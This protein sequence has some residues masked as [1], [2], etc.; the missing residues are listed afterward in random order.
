M[1]DTDVRLRLP[2]GLAARPARYRDDGS[3]PVGDPADLD[4]VL[5]L[6]RACETVTIGEQ[7]STRDEV[8]E[9]FRSPITDRLTT[10]M[11]HDGDT[12]VGFVW[13]EC[14]PTGGNTWI[15]VYVDPPR[16]DLVGAFIDFGRAVARAHR[17]A[18]SGST[19]WRLRSG[20]Y[21]QDV[22]LASAFEHHGLTRVRRFWRMRIDLTSAGLPSSEPPLPDEV[23]ILDGCTEPVR[24]TLFETESAAFADHWDHVE[25]PYEEWLDYV[26]ARAG[27]DPDGW[28]LLTV[29][30]APAAVCIIDESRA[31]TG[32]GYIRSLSVLREFRGRGLAKLLLRRAFVRYRDRGRLG[33]QLGVDSESPTGANHLYESVGMRPH[34]VI[35]AWEIPIE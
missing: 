13:V 15:D 19:T 16:P 17:A 31:E 3:G 1:T 12:L 30:G 20:S 33:V 34:R 6:V 8:E 26:T 23:A 32:D 25:R 14:D 18:A 10:T 9:M 2:D 27:N 11:V 35:D 22:A 24:R 5:T 21:A 7:D 29:G 4:A 28:W